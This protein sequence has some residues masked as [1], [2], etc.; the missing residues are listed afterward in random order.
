[1][2]GLTKR[3]RQILNFVTKEIEQKGYPPSIR[4]IGKRMGISSLRG[5]TIHLDALEKKG[6][7]KRNSSARSI[8]ILP[9]SSEV[10]TNIEVIKLPLVGRV[11]AGEPVLAEE[12]IEDWIPVPKTMVKNNKNA[13]L[14]KVNGDSMTRDHIMDGDLVIVKPQPVADNGDIVVAVIDDEATVKRFYHEKDCIRLQPSNPKYKPI[15][16]KRNFLIN[17]KV[18]GVLQNQTR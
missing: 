4:E 10:I 15:I 18:I 13:F 3:Q 17:G 16:L 12:Y 9:T 11:A 8:K 5:V 7:I 6:Y 14:L 1:M 2:D